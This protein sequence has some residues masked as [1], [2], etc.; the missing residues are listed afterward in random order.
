FF[1]DINNRPLD[2]AGT[3]VIVEDGRLH[4]AR[5]P[6][7]YDVTISE[8]SNP[9]ISGVA[10]LF[11]RE[12]FRSAREALRPEG[13]LL[14]WV[15]LYGLA[16]EAWT[17]ILGALGSEFPHLYIFSHSGLTGGDSLVFAAQRP[18]TA[19]DFPRWE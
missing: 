10:S 9:W 6:A 8:P 15:Q 3:S 5:R 16:P 2:R 12:F 14:Q 13:I 1:D 19:A 17:S 11:T 4:L 7:A 18:L